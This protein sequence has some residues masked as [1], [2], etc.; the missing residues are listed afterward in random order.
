MPGLILLVLFALPPIAL[1]IIILVVGKDSG[2]SVEQAFRSEFFFGV[3]PGLL[4]FVILALAGTREYVFLRINE[5]GYLE[6]A[7][8]PKYVK[9]IQ[10]ALQELKIH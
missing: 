1:Y 4:Y 6:Y 3:L 8:S 9:G 2:S 7:A 10:E 5:K